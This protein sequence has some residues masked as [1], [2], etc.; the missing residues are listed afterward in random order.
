MDDLENKLGAILGNPEMMQQIMSLAQKFNPSETGSKQEPPM[1]K[2]ENRQ[3]PPETGFPGFPELD[4]SMIQ[5]I[6]GF[7]SQ[8]RID[9]N[10]QS[11]LRALGPYLSNHRISK[12]E[13]AMRAAKMAHMA[14][15]FLSPS[16]R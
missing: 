8:S 6:S 13:K 10:Q 14:T 2:Q 15:A 1:Q 11:L 5:K 4:L 12:L 16:G 9:S 7:A 3:S